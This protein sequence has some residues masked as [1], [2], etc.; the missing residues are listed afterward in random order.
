MDM[1][2]FDPKIN[3]WQLVEVEDLDNQIKPRAGHTMTTIDDLIFVFGG[4][5]GQ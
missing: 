3:L 2:V 5:C 4:S 1:L